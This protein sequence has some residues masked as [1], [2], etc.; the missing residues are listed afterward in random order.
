M[1]VGNIT[2]K[3]DTNNTLNL[4]STF[5]TGVGQGVFFIKDENE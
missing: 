1:T 4:Y 5:L 2:A 3:Y